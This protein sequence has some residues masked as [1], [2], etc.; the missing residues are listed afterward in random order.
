MCANPNLTSA[1]I[2]STFSNETTEFS[3]WSDVEIPHD[4]FT[5]LYAN[6]LRRLEKLFFSIASDSFLPPSVKNGLHWL[7]H[8]AGFTEKFPQNVIE[9]I[10]PL[11]LCFRSG[12]PSQEEKKEPDA[13]KS[14]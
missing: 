5:L 9:K 10:E 6:E 7:L 13:D 12:F 4:Y 14:E 2:F 11:F 3:F 8:C 1:T